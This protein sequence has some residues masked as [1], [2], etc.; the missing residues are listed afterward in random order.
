MQKV[1]IV[2]INNP[3]F[4]SAKKLSATLQGGFKVTHFCK[5]SDG[6]VYEKLDDVLPDIWAHDVIIFFVATGIVVRKIAPFLEHKSK[7]PA[8]LV[9]NLD[10]TQVVPLLS[11]HLGGANEFAG[12]LCTL[13]PNCTPFITT[14]SDSSGNFAFDLWAKKK[15]FQIHNL[16]LLA[17][18]T[19][20][21]INNAKI[22][23]ISYKSVLD[24]LRAEIKK[25]CVSFVDIAELESVDFSTP[26]LLVSPLDEKVDAL[27]FKIE[28]VF[29]GTGMNRNTSAD[30]IEQVF[31]EF[32]AKYGLELKSVGGIASF[33]PKS[34][35]VGFLEF[36]KKYDF[37]PQFFDE[38]SI[39]S[40]TQELSPSCAKRFFGIKGVAE[41]SAILASRYK[42][43]FIKKEI[44]GNVTIAAGF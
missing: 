29:I 37:T 11:G 17:P 32:L 39:N 24:E 30:E 25:E 10:M 13:L 6:V 2:S 27:F 18:L 42:E 12:H 41:P 9:I 34:D 16:H 4:E 36:C 22:S 23:V 8:V 26:T 3:G 5:S 15:G 14:A 28:P 44:S 31:L 43:L 33:T 38:E 7:D 20:A 19:N 1:A 40:L 21:L 35:E